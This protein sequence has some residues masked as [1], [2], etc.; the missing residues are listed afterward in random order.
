M[1]KIVPSANV[2]ES[3]NT[4]LDLTF[5]SAQIASSLTRLTSYHQVRVNQFGNMFSVSMCVSVHDSR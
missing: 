2:T 1:S 5:D 3:D 4:F